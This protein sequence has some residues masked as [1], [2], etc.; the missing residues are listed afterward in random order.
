[1][2]KKGYTIYKEIKARFDDENVTELNAL[3]DKWYVEVDN[4]EK[5]KS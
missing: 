5:V 3:C 2:I 1:M 4:A